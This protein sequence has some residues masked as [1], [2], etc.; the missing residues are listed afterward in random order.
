MSWFLRIVLFVL[1]AIL[2]VYTYA[3]WRLTAALGQL[4]S[5]P[6]PRIRWSVRFAAG[7]L[8]I[9]PLLLLLASLLNA[10]ALNDALRGGQFWAK[11]LFIFPFWIG[12]IIVVEIFPFLLALDLSRFLLRPLFKKYQ[13]RWLKSQAL[14]TI[15]LFAILAVYVPIRILHDTY[16]VRLSKREAKIP[17]L[18]AELDGFRLV[19]LSDLQA[20]TF[21]SE[22]KM[23]RYINLAN[24]QK[25][26]L[27]VFC[28]DLVTRGTDHIE[29]G[30]KM[31][32]RL[33]ARLGVYACLGDHDYWANPHAIAQQLKENHVTTIEDSVLTLA[34]SPSKI[35]LT[36]VTNIYNRRP[37]AAT[38]DRLRQQRN[39]TAAVHLLLSHQ[40]SDELI[41]FAQR[42]GYH[43]LLAGHTHGGQVV[44]KPFGIPLNVS[45]TETRYY[46]GFYQIGSL[47]L[48]VNNG[49]GL[50]FAP[51]RY[52]APAEVTLIVLKRKA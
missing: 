26:D 29:R 31:M 4:T 3:G 48:S 19:Q 11:L 23:L 5:W 39:D 6:R 21:T 36:T 1:P 37:S 8:A 15:S 43:L 9:Y 41:Q 46:S 47:W 28:G 34:A 10:T 14:L 40:P 42:Q 52:Q 2:L 33:Q 7:Y 27:A 24:S 38:L 16:S 22:E 20:D 45:Q 30:A 25:P 18:P 49:L 17:H 50:T 12:L 32:G 13:S 51:L 35:S 44:F